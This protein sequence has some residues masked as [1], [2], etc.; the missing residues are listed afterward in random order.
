MLALCAI[1]QAGCRAPVQETGIAP[2]LESEPE[3]YSATVILT[4]EDGDRR[5]VTVTRVARSG[6]MFREEWSQG[7]ER[8]ALILR[9]DLGKSFVL[10]LDRRTYSESLLIDG[11]NTE[12]QKNGGAYAEEI[13]RALGPVPAAGKIESLSLPDHAIDGHP[14]QVTQARTLFEDGRA[15]VTR[16]FRARDLAGLAIRVETETEAQG[17]RVRIITE[18]RDI[19]TTVADDEFLIP[20]DF[21]LN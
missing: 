5:E 4:V 20:P 17:R 21:V 16:V 2:L 13:E 18:R 1:L 10:Y 14:C 7:G 9:P 15:E 11:Q 12:A 6:E 19:K 3:R 8:R